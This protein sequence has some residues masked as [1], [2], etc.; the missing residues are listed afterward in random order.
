MRQFLNITK[1]LADETRLRIVMA[2]RQKE[3]C[4]CQIIALLELAPSTVSRHLYLLSQAGVIDKRKC[5]KWIYCSH[6]ARP[7]P[8]VRELLA[9][10]VRTLEKESRIRHDDARLAAIRTISLEEIC[11]S[12][13]ATPKRKP[14]SKPF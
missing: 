1:A 13:G 8:A 2:L 7:S 11:G 14:K 6:P 3:L 10:T 9:M 12:H 4:A 5:G